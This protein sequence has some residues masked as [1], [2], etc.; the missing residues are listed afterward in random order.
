M[1]NCTAGYFMPSVVS[2]PPLLPSQFNV[3]SKELYNKYSTSGENTQGPLHL[4]TNV[5]LR[6]A[7]GLPQC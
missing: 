6:S 1:N 2:S 7:I 3:F 4:C 5:V